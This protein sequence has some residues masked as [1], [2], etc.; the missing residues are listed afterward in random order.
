MEPNEDDSQG[1][2]FA[3]DSTKDGSVRRDG[4]TDVSH[5]AFRK[6]YKDWKISKEDLFFFCY[7][8]LHS[9][10]FRSEFSSDLRK[11]LPRIPYAKDFWAFSKSGRKLAKWHLEYET[12]DPYPVKEAESN[13]R[14]SAK[15]RYQVT[16]M[17]FGKKDGKPDK[18]VIL[19]NGHVTL[20]GIPLEA[21]EYIVNGKPALEWIM[22][23]YQVTVDKDSGIKNDPNEWSDDPRYIVD[24]IKRIVRVSLETVKIV[25]GLPALQEHIA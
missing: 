21:Y 24:L 22:E 10:A 6:H 7:G 17:A 23:R 9:A 14:L 12:V 18:S 5:E 25:N 8:V 15:E 13:T 1:E 11:M 3:S 19:Y 4:I 16:K 20:S 2:M